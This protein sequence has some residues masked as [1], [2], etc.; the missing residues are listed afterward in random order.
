MHG[1]MH[2][3]CERLYLWPESGIG[4]G[5][6]DPLGGWRCKRQGVENLAGVQPLNPVNSHPGQ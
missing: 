1:F 5:L 4:D 2:F 6:I 3:Y